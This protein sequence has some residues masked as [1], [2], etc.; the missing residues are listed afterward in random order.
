MR[1]V[2]RYVLRASFTSYLSFMSYPSFTS[3]L[4]ASSALLCSINAAMRRDATLDGTV[5][6]TVLYARMRHVYNRVYSYV[7]YRY[8]YLQYCY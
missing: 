3:H 4:R 5:L 8:G 2:K 6:R 7:S 1:F